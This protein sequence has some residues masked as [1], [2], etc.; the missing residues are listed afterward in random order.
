VT[1][2]LHSIEKLGKN[3]GINISAICDS[4]VSGIMLNVD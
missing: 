4:A 1:P 2:L 3:N